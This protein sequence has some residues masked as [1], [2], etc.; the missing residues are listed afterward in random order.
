MLPKMSQNVH[1]QPFCNPVV[2]ERF[3]RQRGN[4]SDQILACRFKSA[5]D[6]GFVHRRK[7]LYRPGIE[8]V[9]IVFRRPKP[10]ILQHDFPDAYPFLPPSHH[11]GQEI[12]KPG[13]S[14]RVKKAPPVLV[15]KEAEAVRISSPILIKGFYQL[16]PRDVGHGILRLIQTRT[17]V[18]NH[19]NRSIRRRTSSPERGYNLRME[20]R[21]ARAQKVFWK[22]RETYGVPMWQ[23]KPAVDELISTILSQNTNDANR[24][25]AFTA[26]RARF[27]EWETV[28]SSPTAEV[29]A[30]I[31][32]AGLGPQKGPRI[33]AV[34]ATIQKTRGRIDLEFLREWPP[35]EARR[36][37]Q[38]PPGVGPKTAAIVMLFA[39]GLP[40]FPVDTHVYRVTGRLGLRPAKMTAAA[41][42]EHLA[43][44]F[45]PDQYASAHLNLIRLG[46]EICHA[47]KPDCP[48]CALRRMCPYFR[49]LKK[50]S[51]RP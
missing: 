6:S 30:A 35:D 19:F 15:R 14:L 51:R 11:V 22:L 47:R 45:S 50:T 39:L 5:L 29:V 40:A 23:P 41:A 37:L 16:L 34:L 10:G 42:H 1:M 38:Q 4:L 25:K 8:P 43:N 36:W 12:R 48:H 49:L 44:L 24:D 2:L 20:S 9:D 46:R 26:L 13:K 17:P 3:F 28:P 33:Q 21:R 32:P 27:P 7:S 31:R 18:A